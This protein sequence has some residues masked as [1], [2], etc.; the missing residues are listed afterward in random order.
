MQTSIM[1]NAEEKP[2]NF[3]GRLFLILIIYRVVAGRLS[4]IPMLVNAGRLTQDEL[5]GDH[6][7]KSPHVAVSVTYVARV[8]R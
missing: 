8:I 4:C 3:I 7:F 1:H 2:R 5:L 6:V